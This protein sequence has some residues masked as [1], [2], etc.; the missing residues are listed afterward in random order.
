[1]HTSSSVLFVFFIVENEVLLSENNIECSIVPNFL[2]L[3]QI[4]NISVVKYLTILGRPIQFLD[5]IFFRN[6]IFVQVTGGRISKSRLGRR[7][8]FDLKKCLF[9]IKLKKK[10]FFKINKCLT[11][12]FSLYF[13]IFLRNHII[14]PSIDNN[15][16]ISLVFC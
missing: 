5:Y 4:R 11:L 9:D 1:M 14:C 10:N 6:F 16:I 13:S 8:G 2:F 3:Y 15:S 7:L 12:F